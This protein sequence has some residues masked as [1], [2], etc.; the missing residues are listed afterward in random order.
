MKIFNFEV[1][2]KLDHDSWVEF[3]GEFD[4]NSFEAVNS[5]FD[6]LIGPNWP[7]IGQKMKIFNCEVEWKLDHHYLIEFDGDFDG[8][9]FEAVNPY[10]DPRIGHN[11]L[12]IGQKGKYWILSYFVEVK[13]DQYFDI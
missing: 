12:I 1:E 5:Y 8:N 4:G 2:W 9:S 6:L 13:L 10:F 11:W 7:I 3:D